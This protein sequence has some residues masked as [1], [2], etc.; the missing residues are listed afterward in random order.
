MCVFFL[1]KGGVYKTDLVN[2]C[3]GRHQ[4][5]FFYFYLCVIFVIH[6]H[7]KLKQKRCQNN[8]NLSRIGGS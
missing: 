1:V 8:F 2:I 7:N 3:D 5:C 4:S 6:K